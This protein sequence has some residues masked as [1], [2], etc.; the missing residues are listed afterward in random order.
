MYRRTGGVTLREWKRWSSEE[1]EKL[2]KE[3]KTKGPTRLTKEMHGRTKAAIMSRYM[4]LTKYRKKIRPVRPVKKVDK[5][6]FCN[7][8]HINKVVSWN[9]NVIYA[10]YCMDCLSEFTLDGQRIPPLYTD[11]YEDGAKA[12]KMEMLY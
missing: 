5:C 10:Y 8:K 7:S 2:L 4:Y 1:D 11:G 3:Y 6:P 12:A 9:E